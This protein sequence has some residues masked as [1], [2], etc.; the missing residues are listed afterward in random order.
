MCF[1]KYLTSIRFGA[2]QRDVLLHTIE[3]VVYKYSPRFKIIFARFTSSG[4]DCLY[5]CVYD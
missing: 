2:F 3:R 1:F 5:D 4:L